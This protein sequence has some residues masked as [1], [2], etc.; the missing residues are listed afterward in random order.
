MRLL[1]RLLC[2]PSVYGM[3]SRQACHRLKTAISGRI[4]W[5]CVWRAHSHVFLHV[6][7][8]VDFDTAI[9]FDTLFKVQRTSQVS[10][11]SFSDLNFSF[12][13]PFFFVFP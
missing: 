1:F 7:T 5:E 8:G 6:V 4:A 9:A 13:L 3:D 11:S 10:S 12:A 2:L